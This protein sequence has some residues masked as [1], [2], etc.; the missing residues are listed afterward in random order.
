MHT[1]SWARDNG[2]VFASA[3]VLDGVTPSFAGSLSDA[4][5][6]DAN[7]LF[8]IFQSWD[9]GTTDAHG[10]VTYTARCTTTPVVDLLADTTLGT[11]VDVDGTSCK[12]LWSYFDSRTSGNSGKAS[13]DYT[14]DSE[15]IPNDALAN[16]ATWLNASLASR[17]YDVG[18]FSYSIYVRSNTYANSADYISGAKRL[19][20]QPNGT[21]TGCFITL[22]G[23]KLPAYG[24]STP[25]SS[26]RVLVY[27]VGHRAWRTGT[28]GVGSRTFGSTS[29]YVYD[30]K[31]F[32]ATSDWFDMG[33]MGGDR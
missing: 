27:D 31:T 3:E 1:V 14:C 7:G 26:Y 4:D 20:T 9:A 12:T 10:N 21:D 25:E 16:A 15:A 29:Y 32:S 18:G 22:L 8:H 30:S 24:Q 11:N 33:Q 23:G 6:L 2:H 13:R 17:G 28:V 5:Y 19:G